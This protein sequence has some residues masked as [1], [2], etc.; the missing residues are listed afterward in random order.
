[1]ESA[2]KNKGFSLIELMITVSIVGILA[3]IAIPSYAAYTKRANRTDATRTIT[4]YAQALER[5]YSQT[6]TYVGCAAAPTA[7][8]AS[9]QGY[10][11]ITIATATA[12]TATY[13]ITAVPVASPQLQ[14]S[15]CMHF[16]VDNSGKQSALNSSG[17][18]NTK[19]C[20]GSS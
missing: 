19:T 7:S 12:P 5:C 8:V 2:M 3:A 9:P 14:D 16:A 15:S 10:Y 20:W 1:M 18:D 17:L 6:F 13:S 4:V 11:T